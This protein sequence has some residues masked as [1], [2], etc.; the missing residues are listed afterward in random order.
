MDPSSAGPQ[1]GRLNPEGTSRRSSLRASQG[2]LASK[3]KS[4]LKL[5]DTVASQRDLQKGPSNAALA[6]AAS[7]LPLSVRLGQVLP[8]PVPLPDELLPGMVAIFITSMTQELFKVKPGEDVTAEK[9]IKLI[10]K[11]DILA[12]M[13]ARAAVSDWSPLKQQINVN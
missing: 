7:Q 8:G 11:A 4:Q 9:P 5:N 2:K 1:S 10:P 13:F 12:D 6:V 3:S